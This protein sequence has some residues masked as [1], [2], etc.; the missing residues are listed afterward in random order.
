M[1]NDLDYYDDDNDVLCLSLYGQASGE[2]HAGPSP[3]S[4]VREMPSEDTGQRLRRDVD[5]CDM[6][7]SMEKGIC[8]AAQGNQGNQ[9]TMSQQEGL[10]SGEAEGGGDRTGSQQ[11][12][13]G[14]M[15]LAPWQDGVLERLGQA[16]SPQEFNMYL[17]HHGRMLLTFG[18]IQACTPRD[19]DFVYGSLEPIPLQSLRSFKARLGNGL[20]E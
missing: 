3:E 4:I 18:Q 5:L 20:F 12:D 16:L 8:A 6:M 14:K 19:K 10:A 11:Q 9:G 17:V 2:N 13:V 15:G 7:F 1:A